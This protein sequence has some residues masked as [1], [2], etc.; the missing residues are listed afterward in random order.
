MWKLIVLLVFIATQ[1][2]FSQVD[3]YKVQKEN[4]TK[5]ESLFYDF[6]NQ[7]NDA[8]NGRENDDAHHIVKGRR[9]FNLGDFGCIHSPILSP[10][11][12]IYR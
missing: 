1:T 3:E 7:C 12:V 2:A 5:K 10:K 4:L 6:N 11:R 8:G 9:F